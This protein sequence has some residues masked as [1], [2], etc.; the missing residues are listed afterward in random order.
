[1]HCCKLACIYFIL[2]ILLSTKIFAVQ[3]AGALSL[4]ISPSPQAN[5][6]G[7]SYGTLW[8]RDPMAGIFNPAS[9]GLF[10]QKNK[11]GVAFYTQ[12]AQ[13]P[14]NGHS[15]C[16]Y[17]A[18]TLSLGFDAFNES[19][20]PMRLGLNYF[21]Y[22]HRV[23]YLVGAESIDPSEFAQRANGLTISTVIDLGL[24]VSFGYTLK[25]FESQNGLFE[26]AKF[27]FGS[28]AFAHDLGIILQ[29]PLFETAFK[30][31][32]LQ[33][34]K[35]M[36]FLTPN[37]HLSRRNIGSML[38]YKDAH[39]KDPLPRQIYTGLA[40]QIGLRYTA[41]PFQYDL[42][43]FHWA[44]EVDDIL[45]RH[46]A[47][48]RTHYLNFSRT[49]DFMENVLLDE[50][51]EKIAMHQ[52]Y[53]IGLADIVF[54]RRGRYEY[55]YGDYNLDTRGYGIN[56]TQAIRIF[57]FIILHNKNSRWLKV[58]QSFDVEYHT[59]SWRAEGDEAFNNLEFKSVTLSMKKPAI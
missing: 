56:V 28:Q 11:Y 33:S 1:M 20:I 55:L 35:I 58:L 13:W 17:S 45:V 18:W 29:A 34:W 31:S 6:M 36:P 52:G 59:S 57:A 30:Y 16:P 2:T 3:R 24:K 44:R 43:H 14:V 32:F 8:E 49:V 41:D 23:G 42:F 27:N 51:N 37:F 4:L 53:E 21:G 5:A 47:D 19:K 50:S 22:Y 15:R 7:Q 39:R 48:G 12:D 10:A 54:L 38:K 25:Y 46:T 9:V 40:L 26:K